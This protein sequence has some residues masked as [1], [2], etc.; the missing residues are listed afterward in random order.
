M[1]PLW[2]V[3]QALG[4]LHLLLCTP[5]Q[6]EVLLPGH[7][8]F[9]NMEEE[10]EFKAREKMA[11]M[12]LQKNTKMMFLLSSSL[13]KYFKKLRKDKSKMK[14]F[15]GGVE[16]RPHVA[17]L[18]Q[19]CRQTLWWGVELQRCF[20]L[21]PAAARQEG[22]LHYPPDLPGFWNLCMLTA[23]FSLAFINS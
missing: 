4:D 20:S 23:Y 8:G 16:K 11:E 19:M 15:L 21:S 6:E 5:A 3:L 12:F 2:E 22:R 18:A 14:P 1:R 9:V 13:D 17:F 7:G 10:G